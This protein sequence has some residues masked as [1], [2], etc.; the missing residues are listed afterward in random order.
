MHKPLPGMP[1]RGYSY[2]VHGVSF[3]TDSHDGPS[4]KTGQQSCSGADNKTD[5]KW[6]HMH[7]YR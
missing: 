6:I 1:G 3:A 4:E 2:L 7:T 5:I